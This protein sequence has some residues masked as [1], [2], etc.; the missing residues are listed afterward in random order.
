MAPMKILLVCGLLSLLLHLPS[1]AE[2]QIQ[3]LLQVSSNCSVGLVLGV[4][5]LVRLLY[6]IQHYGSLLPIPLPIL[7]L[8]IN[9]SPITDPVL[10]ALDADLFC[11]IT[12][13]IQQI[14]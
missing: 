2:A 7:S 4:P 9:L 3:P 6:I 12:I 5:D 10:A 13:G 11:N 1:E 8:P 14:L